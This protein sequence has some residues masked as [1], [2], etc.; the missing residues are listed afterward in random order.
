M[1]NYNI[2]L[3]PG[4]GV[5]REVTEAAR[6]VL[7]ATDELFDY[8]IRFIEKAIG[9]TAIDSCGDPLPPDTLAA[10]KESDAVF[11]GAVGGPKW[12]GG[13]R[14]P[15]EGLL[16]LR[17][18]MGLFA[19]LRPVKVSAATLAHSPL[20]AEIVRDV[21]MLIVRELTGGSYF[22]AKTRDATSASDLCVY[23]TDEIERVARVAFRAAMER[24]RHVTLVDKANVLETSRLWRETVTGMQKR[25]FPNV[26]LEHV[27]VDTAAMRL[28]QKPRAFD[29]V[30][31]ENMF[32]DIL[33]DEASMLP[34]SIGL[35]GSASLGAGG[36]GLFEPIHGSAPDIA[37]QDLCNPTGA[38]LS[39]AML[40][41]YG[42]GRADEADAVEAAVAAV[43]ASGRATGDLGGR[44]SCSSFSRAVVDALRQTCGV[45]GN[46]RHWGMSTA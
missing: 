24:R 45:P 46:K 42:L 17:K 35:L 41:R 39:A 3:L 13:K 12:D 34:G 11:L 27:L 44:E 31:T 19:N 15:E 40:L 6:R 1:K 33:S 26:T 9:G 7:S 20:K 28:I 36:P 18:E 30:L 5:G 21:D 25:E 14:R 38:I 8:D 4:D 29:V 2:V 37:G 43:L 23:T 32:G 10:C 22:G 16:G